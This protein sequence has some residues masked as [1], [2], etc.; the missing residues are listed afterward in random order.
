[1]CAHLRGAFACVRGPF[2]VPIHKWCASTIDCVSGDVCDLFIPCV[3]DVEHTIP[4]TGDVC[5]G[6]VVC[7]TTCMCMQAIQ[8][9][10]CVSGTD[11][12]MGHV[13]LITTHLY[14]YK[15]SDEM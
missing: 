11:V 9:F 3:H 4:A 6:Y 10:D 12:C 1:M 14:M 8:C 5:V 15:I 13:L 7:I 2:I